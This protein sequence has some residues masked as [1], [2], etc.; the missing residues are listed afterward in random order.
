MHACA[1]FPERSGSKSP[2]RLGP[3]DPWGLLGSRP[4]G[5]LSQRTEGPLPQGKGAHSEGSQLWRPDRGGLAA[6]RRRVAARGY[7]AGTADSLQAAPARR[8]PPRTASASGV[9]WGKK[10]NRQLGA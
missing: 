8:L 6:Q 3:L 1:S 4:G 10:D 5:S 9:V 7:G 2:S